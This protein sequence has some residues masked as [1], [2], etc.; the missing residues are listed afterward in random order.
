MR[1]LLLSITIL[2]GAAAQSQV[3]D[4]TGKLLP[5]TPIDERLYPVDSLTSWAL[6]NSI[7]LGIREHDIRK[8]EL[9]VQ[10]TRS[11]WMEKVST[12]MGYFYSN[13]LLDVVSNGSLTG[14]YESNSLQNRSNYRVGMTVRL[15]MYD[16]IG[17]GAKND[18]KVEELQM[19][20]LQRKQE[21]RDVVRMVQLLYNDLLMKWEVL[22]IRAQSYQTQ[23]VNKT[24][25]EQAFT[26]GEIPVSELSRVT[27]MYAD[28]ADLYQKAK[29]NFHNAYILLEDFV[30]QPISIVDNLEPNPT[31]T[32]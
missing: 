7:A 15:S 17:R 20:H 27:S 19:S 6:H 4:S 25:A 22:Q 5:Q 3:L 1:F 23:W 32:P 28:A 8:N 21:E 29:M 14:I 11:E 2:L 30:G 26:Q 31:E 13:N 12:D 16:L 9:N 10:H 24:M 18:M